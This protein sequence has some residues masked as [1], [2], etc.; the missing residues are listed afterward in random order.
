MNDIILTGQKHSGKT[1]A[2][3]A[4]AKLCL[5]EFIDLDESVLE[6]T[7]KSPRQLYAE[8]QAV[9]QKAEADAA[10]ALFK[11]DDAG[12]DSACT[13]RKRRV[14]ATGGG[15][16]DNE[17][18]VVVLKKSG[19]RIVYLNIPAEIAWERI[20]AAKEL[21]LFLQTENPRETHRALHERRGAAYLQLADIVVKA[22]TQS[23]DEVA[24][25]IFSKITEKSIK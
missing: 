8:G 23:A 16:I 7:G 10:A 3:R 2:G 20:A 1:T 11:T 12:A 15:I 6:R 17:E 19:A 21:P 25:E 22:G 18:A 5:C 24:A 14:I 4:L 9:F 13:D